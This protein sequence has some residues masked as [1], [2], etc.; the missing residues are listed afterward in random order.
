[1]DGCVEQRESATA[2]ATA[3][4]LANVAQPAATPEQPAQF[5]TNPKQGIMLQML[6]TRDESMAHQQSMA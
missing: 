3:P 1:M 2:P 5:V 4:E 6:T